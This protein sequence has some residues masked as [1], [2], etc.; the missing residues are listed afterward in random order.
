[1]PAPKIC[2]QFRGFGKLLTPLVDGIRVMGPLFPTFTD[3][4]AKVVLLDGQG[5]GHTPDSSTSVTTHIT[6]RFSEIVEKH[7]KNLYG[8]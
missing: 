8:G 4:Q 2:F 5:L 7:D 6:R 1:M 3:Y